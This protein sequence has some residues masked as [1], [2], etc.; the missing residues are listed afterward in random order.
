M[1][2]TKANITSY[3]GND[4]APY[5]VPFVVFSLPYLEEAALH[6][7]YDFKTRRSDAI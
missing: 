5:E 7:A 2:Q 1:T 6:G 4:T 3:T